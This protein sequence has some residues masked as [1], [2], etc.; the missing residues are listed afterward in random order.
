[1]RSPFLARPR[2]V[3]DPAEL[4]PLS[5]RAMYLEL[6]RICFASVV[7]ASAALAPTIVVSRALLAT[8]A[9][10]YVAVAAIPQ[11]LRRLGKDRMLPLLQVMLLLDGLYLVYVMDATGGAASP[12]RLLVY[13]HLVAVTLLTSYRTAL[14][15]ALWHTLLYLVLLEA[16]TGSPA[17]R[18]VFASTSVAREPSLW[19]DIPHVA[20]LWMV[21]LVAIACSALSERALRSQKADLERLSMM[22]GAFD[23]SSSPSDIARIL[24]EAIHEAYGFPRAALLGSPNGDPALLGALGAVGRQALEPGLDP[25]MQRAWTDREVVLVRRLDRESALRL[26]RLFPDARN[27]LVVPLLLP[28]GSRLG[29]LLLEH[30]KSDAIATWTVAGVQRFAFHAA[31]ALRSAWSTDDGRIDLAEASAAVR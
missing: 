26:A 16:A 31:L 30:P 9:L 2:S 5:E 15:I 25:L 27:V 1:M 21:A 14:K 3:P 13:A 7:I 10:A 19:S 20:G 29:L 8:S 28:G 11:M 18:G 24:L 23:Q 17:L 6:V 12:L 4:A 22:I